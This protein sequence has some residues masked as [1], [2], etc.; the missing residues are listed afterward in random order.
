MKVTALKHQAKK[1]LILL[2]ALLVLTG[3]VPCGAA[4]AQIASVVGAR[5]DGDDTLPRKAR[6]ASPFRIETLPVGGGAELLTVFGSLDGLKREGDNAQEV[7]LVSILRDTLGDRDP[8]NDRLRQVWMLTYTRP[9]AWQRFA[10]A[11]PFLYGRVGDRKRASADSLPP[12]VLDLA[13]PKRDMWQRF[14]WLALQN[15]VFNPYG[16]AV[17]ASAGALRHN[18]ERYRQAHILRALAILSLYEAETGAESAFTPA[19]SAEIQSRLMLT[20]KTFGG[21]IADSYLDEVLR[22]QSTQQLDQRG[23]NWELLRQRAETEG[24]YFEPLA[25]PDG[26]A[27]HALLWVARE[28]LEKNRGRKFG[29]RFLNIASPWGDSRLLRWD[30]HVETRYLDASGRP[31]AEGTEGARKVELIPLALYGLDFPKIPVV[32]VDFR[33]SLNPKAREA[34]HRVIE[35]VARNVLSLSRYGDIHYFLGRTVFDFVTSRRGI[36]VNQP[37]RLRAYSQLK[38]LLSLDATLDR[39]LHEEIARRLE[40]VS[41][42]PLENDLDA[43]ARLARQQY[44]ALVNAAKAPD[45]LA[46]RIDRDRRAE[47]VPLE[48]GRAGRVM[49]RF[50]NVLSLGLYKHREAAEPEQVRLTLDAERRLAFHKRFLQQ[51]ARSTPVVEVVWNIEDVRRS[52]RYVAEAG[53][54]ADAGAAE[55]AAKIFAQTEDA[56]TRRLCLTS[57]YR[58]DNEVAKSALLRLYQ[59]PGLDAELRTLTAQYL[60]DALRED[61]RI[62]PEDAKAIISVVGQ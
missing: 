54:R 55:A 60:R 14:M 45:G 33:S 4:R 62:A 11:V 47:M 30:G 12:P 7:P 35:D 50:A 51:V 43:E 2:L 22:R 48:H 21:L 39:D 13:D 52:L 58:I 26:G 9:T 41:L 8:E 24:L 16:R 34:S 38:L 25:M 18:T 28:D 49:L 29:S 44:A 1:S 37:S 3:L 31:V 61:Q 27:T 56:E 6:G 59:S 40:S 19:E 10:S 36:D 42:N 32:L 17:K 57:L 15:V 20:S 23:H 46:A 5:D 53:E